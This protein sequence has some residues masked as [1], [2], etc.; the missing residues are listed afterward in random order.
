[1]LATEIGMDFGR[2][3]RALLAPSHRG[4]IEE[5]FST[6]E[7]EARQWLNG[8][9]IPQEHQRMQR[10]M[11]ARYV[12]QDYELSLPVPG[13]RDSDLGGLGIS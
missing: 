4:A 11:D 10:T 3:F 9:G 8:E 12:G 13:D 7:Q 6:M 2:T 1:M 5:L